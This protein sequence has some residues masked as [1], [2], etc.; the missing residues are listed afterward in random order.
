MFYRRTVVAP[1][2][3]YIA[4]IEHSEIPTPILGVMGREETGLLPAPR[5]EFPVANLRYCSIVAGIPQDFWTILAGIAYEDS[6][7]NVEYINSLFQR[8]P[9]DRENSSVLSLSIFNFEP[10]RVS[11]T[12]HGTPAYH[13][14]LRGNPGMIGKERR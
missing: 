10:N 9:L 4:Q 3:N 8:V 14:T 12:C 2:R 1:H 6:E 11:L 7:I 5:G 13:C